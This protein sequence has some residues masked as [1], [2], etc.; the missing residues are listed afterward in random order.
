MISFSLISDPA[1]SLCIFL[2]KPGEEMIILHN[3]EEAEL[4][5]YQLKV[6]QL[7]SPSTPL[8]HR[9]NSGGGSRERSRRCDAQKSEKGDEVTGEGL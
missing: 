2:N 4:I 6:A 1:I 8:N 5:F 7:F 3:R 9:L